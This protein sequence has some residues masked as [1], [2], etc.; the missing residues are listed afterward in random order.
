MNHCISG[1]PHLN[2]VDFESMAGVSTMSAS[3]W[4]KKDKEAFSETAK[5]FRVG[6]RIP[7]KLFLMRD[8]ERERPWLRVVKS[9]LSSCL[10]ILR[11]MRHSVLFKCTE[12]N[13]LNPQ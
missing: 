7:I 9:E 1:A 3:T 8:R 6:P 2:L 5:C 10:S 13:V 11:F 12:L 4:E